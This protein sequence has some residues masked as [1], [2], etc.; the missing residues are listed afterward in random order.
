MCCRF[1]TC[2][3][4]NP[5][6]ATKVKTCC[7]PTFSFSTNAPLFLIRSDLHWYRVYPT[8]PFSALRI[9]PSQLHYLTEQARQ[10]SQSITQKKMSAAFLTHSEARPILKLKRWKLRARRSMEF[11]TVA[12]RES[13]RLEI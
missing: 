4:W 5:A 13:N 3:A 2:F 10:Y 11:T 1:R 6:A 9:R 8:F 12:I 7:A